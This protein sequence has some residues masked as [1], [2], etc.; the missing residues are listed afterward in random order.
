MQKYG[1]HARKEGKNERG[2]KKGGKMEMRLSLHKPKFSYIR[3]CT[4]NAVVRAGADHPEPPTGARRS[5]SAG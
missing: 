4:G 3:S 2:E 5:L 1:Y